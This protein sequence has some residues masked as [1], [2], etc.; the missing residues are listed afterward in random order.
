MILVVGG[1]AV[2]HAQPIGL[3]EQARG[4]VPEIHRPLGR[5]GETSIASRTSG[6]SGGRWA[7]CCGR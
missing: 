7:D 6:S 2:D 4:T 1:H 3:P 5:A